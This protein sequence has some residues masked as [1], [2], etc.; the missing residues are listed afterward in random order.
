LLIPTVAVLAL[1]ASV[2]WTFA[3]IPELMVFVF[4]PERRHVYNPGA[5]AQDALLPAES[6]AGPAVTATVEIWLGA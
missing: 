4:R 2:I 6:A 1:A 5:A 3:T